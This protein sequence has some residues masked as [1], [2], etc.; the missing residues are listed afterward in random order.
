MIEPAKSNNYHGVTHKSNNTGEVT[1]IGEALTWILQQ[2]PVPTISYKICSDSYYGIDAVDVMPGRDSSRICNRSLIQW[3]YDQLVLSRETES[4]VQRRKIKALCTDNS[5]DNRRNFKADK[6]AK[7]GRLMDLEEFGLLP[8]PPADMEAESVQ[9]FEYPLDWDEDSHDLISSTDSRMASPNP[10][11][12][13]GMT[14]ISNRFT[15]G[16]P[17]PAAGPGHDYSPCTP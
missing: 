10:Q 13:P 9:P 15:D 4:L 2:Q 17:K 5:I 1:A 12:D 16:V 11:P 3:A 7:Q 6:L 8:D 14:N